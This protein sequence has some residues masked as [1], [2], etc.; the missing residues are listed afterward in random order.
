[1]EFIP[2]SVTKSI[3]LI[4]SSKECNRLESGLFLRTYSL[5]PD[6]HLHILLALFSRHL[7]HSCSNTDD[8]RYM[9]LSLLKH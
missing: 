9:H 5:L 4:T 1:M 3:A 7:T 6:S 2:L 8:F